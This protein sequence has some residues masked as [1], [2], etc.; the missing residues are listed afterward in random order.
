MRVHR[1]RR[2]GHLVAD[3]DGPGASA[4]SYA[5]GR[6]EVERGAR[7]DPR[8]DPRQHD[9]GDDIMAPPSPIRRAALVGAVRITR[10][11]RRSNA[12]SGT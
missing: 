3:S 1:R 4:T 12:P 11:C 8:R 10:T 5:T 9:L 2:P 7:G 6:P